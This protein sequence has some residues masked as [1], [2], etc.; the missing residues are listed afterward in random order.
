MGVHRAEVVA[1]LDPHLGD[2]VTTIC[3]GDRTIVDHMW[4]A[5]R[6]FTVLIA[7]QIN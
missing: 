6:S 4:S 2:R 1:I 5:V 3:K 7:K